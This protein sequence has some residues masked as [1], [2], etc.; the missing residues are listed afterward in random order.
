MVVSM[1]YILLFIC[2][3]HKNPYPRFEFLLLFHIFVFE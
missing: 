1:F 2:E 3:N